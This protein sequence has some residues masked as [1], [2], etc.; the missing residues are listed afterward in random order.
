MGIANARRGPSLLSKI[1]LV[2]TKLRLNYLTPSP[3]MPVFMQIQ[4]VFRKLHRL[5]AKKPQRLALLYV[6]CHAQKESSRRAPAKRSLSTF[7]FTITKMCRYRSRIY[8]SS[9][10]KALIKK[11]PFWSS[12]TTFL[13]WSLQRFF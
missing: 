5:M 6:E 4:C 9:L 3:T 8:S 12:T 13:T 7:S 1:Y 11:P 2:R 10:T